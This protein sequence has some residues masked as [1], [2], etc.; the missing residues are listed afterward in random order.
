[1]KESEQIRIEREREEK[2][3]FTCSKFLPLSGDL[4]LIGRAFL[5]DVYSDIPGARI[6]NVPSSLVFL[7]SF[8]PPLPDSFFYVHVS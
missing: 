6:I 7:P 8:S 4:L 1:M 2:H 3:S 5:Y